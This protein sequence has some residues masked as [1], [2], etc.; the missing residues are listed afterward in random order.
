V[1]VAGGWGAGAGAG[2]G[3]GAGAGAATDE[4]EGVDVG[5]SIGGTAAGKAATGVLGFEQ[6]ASN[7]APANGRAAM[8]RR[9]FAVVASDF[10][11][12]SWS[13]S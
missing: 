8:K 10:N 1:V 6:A 3:T 7:A 13:W 12:V 2:D 4:A 5:V 9:R 11:V